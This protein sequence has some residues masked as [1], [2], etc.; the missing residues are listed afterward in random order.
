MKLNI[1]PA[2]C[3]TSPKKLLNSKWTALNPTNKEKHFMVTKIMM[4]EDLNQAI[5][6]VTIEAVHSKR[7]QVLAWL[8]LNDTTI[9]RQGWH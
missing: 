6:F 7:S 8:D 4:P 9:W 3:I 1:K 2:K 5:A